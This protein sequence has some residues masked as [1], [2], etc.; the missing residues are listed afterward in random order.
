MKAA[1]NTAYHTAHRSTLEP[2][3]FLLIQGL[4][5]VPTS[6]QVEGTP[7]VWNTV[8]TSL[9]EMHLAKA[10]GIACFSPTCCGEICP[11]LLFAWLAFPSASHALAQAC[12]LGPFF[13]KPKPIE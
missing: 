3:A 5:W 7:E 11:P 13:I 2:A 1:S 10:R 8:P 6:K 12:K 4:D 9:R